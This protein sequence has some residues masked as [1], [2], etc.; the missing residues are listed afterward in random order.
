M[1]RRGQAERVIRKRMAVEGES[2]KL[3]CLLGDASKVII[4]FLLHTILNDWESPCIYYCLPIFRSFFSFDLCK[5]N[6]S[7]GSS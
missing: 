7:V 5:V 2:V 4:K 6:L 1:G 3:W